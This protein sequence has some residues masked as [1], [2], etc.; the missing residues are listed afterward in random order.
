MRTPAFQ[1]LPWPQIVRLARLID[2][3]CS[4]PL[5]AASLL[6]LSCLVSFRL[7][8]Q[9]KSHAAAEVPPTSRLELGFLL[10]G[11]RQERLVAPS[12][13]LSLF[14]LSLSEAGRCS[15]V[16]DAHPLSVPPYLRLTHLLIL[17][18]GKP[19]FSSTICHFFDET[20]SY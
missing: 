8:R 18:C 9:L 19:Y 7:S 14:A 3:A 15:R 13:C 12:L 20:T 2:P 10:C 11:T 6:P 1:S 5:R 16:E 17:S 4:S